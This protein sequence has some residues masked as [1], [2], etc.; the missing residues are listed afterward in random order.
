MTDGIF[1]DFFDFD[2]NG[3]LDIFEQSAEL[4]FLKNLIDNTEKEDSDDFNNDLD[5]DLGDDFGSFDA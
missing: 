3:E 5:D 1:G 2:N 4:V